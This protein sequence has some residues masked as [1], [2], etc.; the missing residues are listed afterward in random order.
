MRYLYQRQIYPLVQMA[1]INTLDINQSV[2]IGEE[3]AGV[4]TVGNGMIVQ[5]SI[6]VGLSESVGNPNLYSQDSL[7]VGSFTTQ[8]IGPTFEETYLLNI[9]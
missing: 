6:T 7:S 5:N 1:G 8:Y 2:A 4:V 9:I 3:Y